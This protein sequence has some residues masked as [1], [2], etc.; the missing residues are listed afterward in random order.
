[1][2][3][4]AIATGLM[5]LLGLAVVTQLMVVALCCVASAWLG[6]LLYRAER[7]AKRP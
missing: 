6:H 3:V 7:A 5:S 4:G 2:V 1:M